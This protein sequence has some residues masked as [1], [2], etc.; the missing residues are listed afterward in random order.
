MVFV[1]FLWFKLLGGQGGH[2]SLDST[3]QESCEKLVYEREICSV[4][5]YRQKSQCFVSVP[6]PSRGGGARR[7][8]LGSGARA[9]LLRG[10][11]SPEIVVA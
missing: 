7:M 11:M 2:L 10:T 3:W 4:F 6:G 5:S 1:S 8:C 9:E